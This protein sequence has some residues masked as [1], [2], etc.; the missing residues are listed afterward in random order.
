MSKTASTLSAYLREQAA[1]GRP[2]SSRNPAE[3]Q[4]IESAMGIYRAAADILDAGRIPTI[5]THWSDQGGWFLEEM[6]DEYIDRACECELRF[7][8]KLR[9]SDSSGIKEVYEPSER[10]ADDYKPPF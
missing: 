7:I 5:R 8:A 9:R 6:P 10:T 3:R 1:A 2:E 4:A